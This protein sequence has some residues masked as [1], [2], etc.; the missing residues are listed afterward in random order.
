LL[1]LLPGLALGH[2]LSGQARRVSE[3]LIEYSELCQTYLQQLDDAKQKAL[4]DFVPQVLN[5]LSGLA[6]SEGEEQSGAVRLSK[7]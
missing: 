3:K 7:D 1:N 6:R 5:A 4:A 2:S